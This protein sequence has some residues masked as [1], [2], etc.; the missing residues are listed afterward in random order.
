MF[1]CYLLLIFY[2][3]AVI[4]VDNY[5]TKFFVYIL[6]LKNDHK[7]KINITFLLKDTYR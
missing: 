1:Y 3:K 4:E 7:F 5:N 2:L 6:I